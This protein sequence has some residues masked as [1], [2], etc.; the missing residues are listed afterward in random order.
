ML[1]AALLVVYVLLGS[2]WIM[3]GCLI[4]LV[5]GSLMTGEALMPRRNM[6]GTK[7]WQN[8]GLPGGG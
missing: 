7:T 1:A 2:G 3:F 4:S 8:D 5:S 6:A